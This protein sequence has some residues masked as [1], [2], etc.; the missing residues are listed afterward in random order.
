MR[1]SRGDR[2][3]Q[4]KAPPRGKL[5][6]RHGKQYFPKCSSTCRP[7]LE[8]SDACRSSSLCHCRSRARGRPHLARAGEAG[9]GR[10]RDAGAAARQAQRHPRHGRDRARGEGGARA[11]RRAAADQRPG[12]RGAR[13]RRRRR[14]CRADRHGAAR[15]R[16]ACSG[17]DAIIGLSIN[18]EALAEAAPI[19]LLDYVGIGGVYATTSKDQKKPPIGVD[20]LAPHRRRVPR[21]RSEIPVLRHRR[22]QCRQCRRDD[23]RRCRRRVGDL[24]A[25]ARARSDRC[26]EGDARRGRRR[27]SPA[28]EA[29]NDRR[30]PSPSPARIPAAAPASRPISRPSPR[31]ASMA[32]AS[33]PR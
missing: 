30:S 25:V 14:A 33:S 15:M 2:A 17:R 8:S 7:G 1:G 23:R 28:A 20:G 24:G 4:Q 29:S 27:R 26:R 9:R 10:R 22:H 21:A 31:S 16:G 5:H 18:T 11:V 19:E 6:F 12:R 13:R 3:I 32:R